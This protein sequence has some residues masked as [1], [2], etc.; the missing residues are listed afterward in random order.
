MSG[1]VE[2]GELTLLPSSHAYVSSGTVTTLSKQNAAE[3]I[4]LSVEVVALAAPHYTVTSVGA[5]TPNS[6]YIN[7]KIIT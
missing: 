4:V 5:R 3:T 2:G 6:I 1:Y 7:I